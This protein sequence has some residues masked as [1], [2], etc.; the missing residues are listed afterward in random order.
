M[1][2][3]H[4]K[5][6]Q[7]PGLKLESLRG[8][9]HDDTPTGTEEQLTNSCNAG[10]INR[11]HSFSFLFFSELQLQ[12][13]YPALKARKLGF[14]CRLFYLTDKRNVISDCNHYRVDM[15]HLLFFKGIK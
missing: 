3:D 7:T 9:L 15:L 4:L 11:K 6:T 13:I 14:H 2:I 12:G 10:N 8:N 1:G 5:D